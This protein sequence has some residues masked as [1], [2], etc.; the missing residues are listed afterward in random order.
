MSKPLA[1]ID[2]LI[3]RALA[4]FER[5][6]PLIRGAPH[7]RLAWLVVAGGMALCVGPFW[8]PP[9]RAV[10]KR[11][12]EVDIDPPTSVGWG[13]V[14]VAV[15]LAYHLLA[16]RADGLRS[17]LQST[18]TREHDGPLIEAFKTDFP[19][20]RVEFILDGL[21][22]D[23]AIFFEQDQFLGRART[24]IQSS[25]FHLLDDSLRAK[26]QELAEG[27][28]SLDRLIAREFFVPAHATSSNR[29]CLRPD[30][31]FDRSGLSMPSRED[32]IKYE[33]LAADLAGLTRGAMTAYRNLIITAHERV[34]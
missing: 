19:E 16:V 20:H 28:E 22:S 26:A 8:E 25:D 17:Q 30:W 3:Q 33:R 7:N 9:L 6:W 18:R 34:L 11:Y 23:H 24:R 2:G 1:F 31:N 12:L 13:V 10:V 14:L 5:V 15:G 4:I 32:E 21:E 27:L 29:S